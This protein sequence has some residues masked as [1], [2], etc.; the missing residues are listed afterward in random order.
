VKVQGNPPSLVLLDGDQQAGEPLQLVTRFAQGLRGQHL[1]S[2]IP[3]DGGKILDL[4][5]I[6]AMRNN[7]LG[8]M[9][10]HD[11]HGCAAWIRL[12]QAVADRGRNGFLPYPV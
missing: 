9:D 5:I 7:D 3:E 12:P 4:T 10:F 11:P 1:F 8:S 2:G 6:P